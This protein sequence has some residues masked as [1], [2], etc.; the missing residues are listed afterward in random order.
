MSVKELILDMF[1]IQFEKPAKI[2]VKYLGD[3]MELTTPIL[4]I[5]KWATGQV[6]YYA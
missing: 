1:E 4:G 3:W 2:S 6:K 5:M